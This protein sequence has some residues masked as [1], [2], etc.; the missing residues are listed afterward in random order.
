MLKWML[1]LH[2]ST[3]C[4]N[5]L[6]CR[7]VWLWHAPIW[8][9]EFVS[10][11]VGLCWFKLERQ[12]FVFFE[13]LFR[14]HSLE[15]GPWGKRYEETMVDVLDLL[16]KPTIPGTTAPGLNDSERLKCLF[17]YI[18]IFTFCTYVRYVTVRY[19]IVH[20]VFTHTCSTIFSICFHHFLYIYMHIYTY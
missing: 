19:D 15:E 3:D 10:L 8:K 2:V 5:I 6:K 7:L 13:A 16:L 17:M 9:Q 20:T 4:F 18:Y 14:G 11:A 1:T 12:N